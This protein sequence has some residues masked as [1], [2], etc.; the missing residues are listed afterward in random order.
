MKTIPGY[1][2]SYA[3]DKDGVVTS[4]AR[5]IITAT[6][7]RL[8]YEERVMQA[9]FSS[10]GTPVCV[11]S[12]RCGRKIFKIKDLLEMTGQENGWLL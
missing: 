1:E 11:L 3:I 2:G 9:Q 10:K 4:L 5:T 6:N 12:K 8:V 7:V